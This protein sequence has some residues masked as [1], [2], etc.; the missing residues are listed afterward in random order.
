MGPDKYFIGRNLKNIEKKQK[1][2][3]MPK[4]CN[5]DGNFFMSCILRN[6]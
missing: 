5:L 2:L 4:I 6:S 3:G 1:V